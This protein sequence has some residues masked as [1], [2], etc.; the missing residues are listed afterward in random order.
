MFTARY[1]LIPYIK[2]IRLV[3]TLLK[4]NEL[5]FVLKWREMA[6]G[7]VTRCEDHHSRRTVRGGTV[8]VKDKKK[9]MIVHLRHNLMIVNWGL[10]SS[11]FLR[12]VHDFIDVSGQ[13][14]GPVFKGQ[15]VQVFECLTLEYCADVVLKR[16]LTI[17]NK[18]C[19]TSQKSK[20][21]TYIA[22]VA[23]NLAFFLNYLICRQGSVAR[24]LSLY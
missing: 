7:P 20:D 19:V 14:I 1:G 13:P 6:A 17:T 10:R 24:H 21:I 3:F 15:E 22:A 12:S 16:Q 23:W 5:D 8:T 18:R 9:I 11:R 4:Y 2:E